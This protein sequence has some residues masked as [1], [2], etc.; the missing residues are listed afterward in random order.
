[1]EGVG[2]LAQAEIKLF[3]QRAAA[4][5]GQSGADERGDRP[6]RHGGDITQVDGHGLATDPPRSGLCQLETASFQ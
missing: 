3:R 4:L 2:H 1:M 5:A 6:A